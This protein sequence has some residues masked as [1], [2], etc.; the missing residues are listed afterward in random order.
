MTQQTKFAMLA[1]T[2]GERPR[3]HLAQVAADL[4]DTATLEE[5]EEAGR[6]AWSWCLP[7]M[8]VGTGCL[9][10]DARE[11]DRLA[12]MA[13]VLFARGRAAR[14]REVAATLRALMR[15]AA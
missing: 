15:E 11:R 10:D 3:W 13:G 1:S 2:A 6:L 5:A 4:P 12:R 8:V 9:M 14:S 7:G